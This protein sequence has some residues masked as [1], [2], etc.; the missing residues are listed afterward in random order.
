[1]LDTWCKETADRSPLYP[2]GAFRREKIP[3][4]L[5][6]MIGALLLRSSTIGDEIQDELRHLHFPL[7]D[8]PFRIVLFS[9]EDTQITAL[10]GKDRHN[11]RLNVYYAVMDRL[12]RQLKASCNG[13]LVLHM[14]YMIG[15]LY[16]GS[17]DNISDAC[18]DVVDYSRDTLGFSLHADVSMPRSG[19]DSIESAFQMVENFERSRSFFTDMS[20]PVFELTANNMERIRDTAQRTNFEQTFFK[21]ADQICGA[22]RAED[23]AAAAQYLRAQLLRIAE[24]SLGLPYPDTLN[25]TVNRF[26]SLLQYRLVGQD[27]ANWRYVS[28]MDFSRDLVSSKN[29]QEFL[30][31]SQEIASALVTH[32]QE[33][34]TVRYDSLMHDIYAYIEE[35]ATDVNMGLTLISRT[36]KLKPRETAESFR[37]YFGESVNDVMH[38]ARV[39]KA[40]DLLL[41]TARSVQ[42]I[43]E[44]VGYCSLA[45]MYRAFSNIEGVA[46]GKLRQNK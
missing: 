14:G 26:I 33:R 40:K 10:T 18:Q 41:T 29:L 37:Q 43:A 21:T 30:D 15:L 20:A 39:R 17:A 32:S 45:T 1:M 25:M 3:E 36:F 46:P 6:G 42:E 9:L 38:R 27:L 19:I 4:G 23:T 31:V 11:C 44:E 8:S 16:P 2:V 22:I 34:T 13:F 5:Y 35:N 24:N 12:C 28:Q 7:P